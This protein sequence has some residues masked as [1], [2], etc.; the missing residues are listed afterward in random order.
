MWPPLFAFPFEGGTNNGVKPHC[1]MTLRDYYAGQA[2]SA[3]MFTASDTLLMPGPRC[4]A[5]WAYAVADAMLAERSKT[6]PTDSKGT[7]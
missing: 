6:P 7:H 1:G 2:L 5:D 4:A 3:M